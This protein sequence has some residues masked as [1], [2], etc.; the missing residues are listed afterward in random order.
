[1]IPLI[2]R[3]YRNHNVVT[4]VFGRPVINRSV[5]NLLK[6]HKFV[7]QI[8]DNGLSVRETFPVLEVLA[9]LDLGPSRI[10]IGKLA[11]GYRT[12]GEGRSL[13]EYV[14]EKVAS[15][16]NGHKQTL[17][18]GQDVVL[19]G[20]GRIG[21]L[22]A[23]ILIE[24]AGSGSGLNL[25]AIV[26]RPG[27]ADNDL[28]KRASLLRRDSVHG[29]FQGT[30]S[31]DEE[32]KV[33]YANGVAIQVIYSSSPDS[34]DYTQYGIN[35][36]VVVDN[37]GKWRDKEGLGLHLQS[38]G[39]SRV[40]LTAPGKGD[41]KNIVYGVNHKDIEPADQIL[42]AASCTTNAITPV[43]KAI[44]DEYGVEHG[45]VETV[46]SY[47]N[48]QNLIDNYHKGER[49]GRSAALNMVITETGAAKA[50]AKALPELEGKLTGNAIRV[51]TPNVSLAILNLSLGKATTVE[52]L[53]SFIRET[54]LYSK[55]QK[56][57]D[58]VTSVEAVSSDFVGSRRAGVV[59]GQ[60]TIV[61][62]KRCVL[63][64]WYDNEF[65]YSCQVNR[66]LQFMSG[67]MYPSVP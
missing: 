37:T 28:Q 26:V 48:D 52:E 66:I 51:P 67:A 45:H 18:P 46:H 5:I 38:K 11:V 43:L 8:E 13:E 53:N 44:N 23:R 47:T 30:I 64:V 21:R 55:L 42:S 16:T 20:F 9:D 56:Q 2:G 27:G 63:Y 60:A 22:M 61:D 58:Y 31:V 62:G 39:V 36:A 49:R 32:N 14:T 15:V 25:R 59:D 12:E 6:A 65:G 3:L 33:I 29:S 35:N 54:S 34:I 17:G 41:I 24:R 10:D 1:M 4:S 19:Y 40:L 7:R 50:V 57:V